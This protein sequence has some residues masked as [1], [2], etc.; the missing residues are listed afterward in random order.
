M[1]SVIIHI[2]VIF[3]VDFRIAL[4]SSISNQIYFL[5]LTLSYKIGIGLLLSKDFVF[6]Y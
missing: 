1:V 2:I 3:F 4:A 5:N 6:D